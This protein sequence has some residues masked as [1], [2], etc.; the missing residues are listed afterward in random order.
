M[1]NN[2]LNIVVTIMENK[3]QMK[4]LSLHAVGDLRLERAPIP[5][6]KDDE[7]LVKIKNCGICGSDI[8]RVFEHGTYSFPTVPGHEFSGQVVFDKS[9][10]WTGKKVAIF[11]LL[12][13][14]ECQMCKEGNYAEC[15]NYDYYG[16]RRDGAWAEYLAVKKF[17]LIEVP[18]SVSYAEAAMCEPIA[19]AVHA[20]SKLNVEKNKSLLISG[21]GPI[22]LIIGHLAKGAGVKDVAYIEIDNEKIKFLKE[23]GFIHYD[24]TDGIKYDYAIEGA[25]ASAALSKL[26]CG[27]KP[28]ASVVL[29]GNPAREMTLSQHHYWKILRG[30]LKLY[31]TWNSFYNDKVNDWK[32]AIKL[33]PD[34]KLNLDKLITHYVPLDKA[35]DALNMMKDKKEFFCKVMIDNER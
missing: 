2:N 25:G 24:E 16:S 5:Q 4:V 17:N 7:V 12:P 27:V 10:E 6:V 8:G 30:E 23:N 13:C 34:G 28:F 1:L 15:T 20:F 22:G 9:G 29:M 32:T 31:G 3:N 35:L 18:E 11:P 26:L 21:A 19:V 14:F 33:I